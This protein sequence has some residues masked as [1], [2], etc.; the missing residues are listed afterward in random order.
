MVKVKRKDLMLLPV[1]LTENHA[2]VDVLEIKNADSKISAENT[3]KKYAV[4]LNI[5][6]HKDYSS[7]MQSD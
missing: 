4:P 1:A 5:F 6:K 7:H 3:R 2:H